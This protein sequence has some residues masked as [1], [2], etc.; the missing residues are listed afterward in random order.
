MPFQPLPDQSPEK[1]N[2]SDFGLFIVRF[3][4]VSAF[5]Y[6]QLL[7]QLNLVRLFVWEKAEWP[8]IDQIR[9]IS[10]PMPE[11][12]ATT[13]ILALAISLFGI[14]LGIFTRINSLILF[15]LTAFILLAPLDLSPTLT[16]QAL[17]LYLALFLALAC[18]G[19]GRVSLDYLMTGKKRSTK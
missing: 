15:I 13:L 3:I 5:V 10:L 4:S 14:S 1:P 17:V 19:A 8:L 11:L 16:R 9:D 7:D 6:Y 12:I 18:G 2:S